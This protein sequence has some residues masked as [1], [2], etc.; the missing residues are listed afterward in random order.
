MVLVVV[1]RRGLSIGDAI[2]EH[3][4]DEDRKLAGRGR[5]RLGF[6][7]TRGPATVEGAQRMIA[8]PETHGRHAEDLR[9]PIGR[10]WR[11]RAEELAPGDLVP[12]RNREPRDEVLLGRPATHVEADLGHELECAIR[13]QAGERRQVDALTHRIQRI[14]DLEAGLVGAPTPRVSGLAQ[15]FGGGRAGRLDG[16]DLGLD[17]VVAVADL[18]LVEVVALDRLAEH[19]QLLSAVVARE[20]GGGLL[21]GGLTAGVAVAGQREDA[22]LPLMNNTQLKLW[23]H[24]VLDLGTAE[25]L[26]NLARQDVT[27]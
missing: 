13:P 4:V 9:R 14:A 22:L 18:G 16:A 27:P 3:T 1:S 10:G 15:G 7:S 8:P 12:R 20:G 17:L 19:E 6:A 24:L 26:V 21:P 11:P 5:D 25:R 2:A 23:T